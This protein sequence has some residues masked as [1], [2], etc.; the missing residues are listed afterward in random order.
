ALGPELA[1]QLR[2]QGGP[3]H[4]GR[5]HGHLVRTNPQQLAGVVHRSHA[6]P[7]GEG[8]EHLL[9]G[10][11]HD[12]DHRLP[13]VGRRSDVVEDDLVGALLVVTG[14]QLHWI[15]RIAEV[16]E[17]DA[18]HHPARVHVE[19]GDHPDGTHAAIASFTVNRP[20]YSARPTMTP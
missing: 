15:A 16:A 10:A 8:D 9:R 3:A 1:G 18:L 7:D 2:H 5:V 14:S 6:A 12:V 17:V 20:S 4:R 19:A 11:A 13:R